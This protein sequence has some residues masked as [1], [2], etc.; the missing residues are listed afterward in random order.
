MPYKMIPDLLDSILINKFS[1]FSKDFKYLKPSNYLPQIGFQMIENL[2]NETCKEIGDPNGFCTVWCI[3]YC[4]QKSLNLE[5][6]SDE[7]VDQLINNIKLEG[8]SFKN[9]IRNFSKN[10]SKL[11]DEYLDMVDLNIN[12]WIL[13][14]F[15]E[16]KLYKLEK[17]IL[18]LI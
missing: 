16:D 7:L 15:E 6:E 9:L 10:I 14:S 11:R 13:S 8:K 4:Y 2:E 1:N 12:R 3:W 18:K 17:N 5:I